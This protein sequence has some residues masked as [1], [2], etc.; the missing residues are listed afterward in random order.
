MRARAT[1]PCQVSAETCTT[2]SYRF[3]LTP[4]GY[5]LRGSSFSRPLL[6]LSTSNLV[7][8]LL[9]NVSCHFST[10]TTPLRFSSLFVRCVRSYW[11][12]L[13]NFSIFFFLS[14]LFCLVLFRV[15]IERQC[16]G[17]KRYRRILLSFDTAFFF[18]SRFYVL[19][20]SH[21]YF[22]SGFYVVI[23]RREMDRG[24]SGSWKKPL[25]E[26]YVDKV[27][28]KIFGLRRPDD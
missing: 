24:E 26:E 10:R 1:W 23:W 7:R 8:S 27:V 5:V 19:P 15:S 22:S 12:F 18:S 21:I 14:F 4:P 9:N 17:C 2:A 11:N 25:L 28:T 3:R 16:S 6:V 13:F 20:W